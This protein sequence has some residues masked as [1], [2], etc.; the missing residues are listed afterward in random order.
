MAPIWHK[1][2]G[3]KRK[4]DQIHLSERIGKEENNSHIKTKKIVDLF[5]NKMG[6]NVVTK[7]RR[8]ANKTIKDLKYLFDRE[9]GN[10]ND[11]DMENEILEQ[12]K[13]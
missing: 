3:R 5:K 4:I 7:S 11:D 6:S 8:K 10:G 12:S 13:D 1:S 2:S 9:E